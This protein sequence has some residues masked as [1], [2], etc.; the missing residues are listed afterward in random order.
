MSKGLIRWAYLRF[1]MI[2]ASI[3]FHLDFYSSV[4][5]TRNPMIARSQWIDWQYVTEL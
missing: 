1:S 4:I 3:A 2:T 5:L